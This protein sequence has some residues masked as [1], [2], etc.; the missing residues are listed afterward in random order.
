VISG[1]YRKITGSKATALGLVAAS[2]KSGLQLIYGGYPI[3]PASEILHELAGYK[4][5]GVK[6]MQMEDEIAA[7]SVAIGASYSGALG[8]TG[9]S[10][11]GLCL[12][13]EAINLAVMAELP[14]IV[15]NIQRAGP[16][17]GV[18]TGTEQADLLQML[19]GRSGESPV[20]VLAAS[21]SADCFETIYE[22]CRIAIRYMTPVIFLSEG[23]IARGM[24]IWRI[25][26][27]SEL[28]KIEVHFRTDPEG[29]APYQRDP[30]TLARPWAVPGT[31]GLEHR[32][33][34]LEKDDTGNVSFEPENHEAMTRSRAEKVARIVQD[35]PPSEI[36]GEPLGQM[37][38]IGW[39]GT[40][41]TLRKAVENKQ[42]AGAS[43]SHLH[44]RYLNPLPG[45]LEDILDRFDKVLIPELNMGQL[46]KIIRARYLVDASGL[47]KV[48]GQ[49]FRVPEIEARIEEVLK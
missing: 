34:G 2:Q 39:G 18:P 45:D 36:F 5:L 14:L 16:S 25:P 11:P 41:S 40:C 12:K 6:A 13:S 4:H 32:I 23:H 37:L 49:I 15:C 43:I 17:T 21:N 3:T 7:I 30:V 1:K 33:G 35:I 20:P 19:F 27:V 26:N 29:F 38:V 46:L 24:E 10:G 44:L 48:Q 47:G 8:A 9:S 28:P 22:A 31:A 42:Q